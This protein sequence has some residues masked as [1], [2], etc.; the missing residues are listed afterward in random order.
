MGLILLTCHFSRTARPI[1]RATCA[2]RKRRRNDVVKNALRF[3]IRCLV[4]EIYAIK[5]GQ[6]CQNMVKKSNFSEN[7]PTPVPLTPDGETTSTPHYFCLKLHHFAFRM[8][9]IDTHS[10]ISIPSK[11]RFCKTLSDFCAKFATFQNHSTVKGLI[12]LRGAYSNHGHTVKRKISA[13]KSLAKS[14]HPTRIHRT[15]D[16]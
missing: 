11:T 16:L 1:W 6:F 4:L 3:S 15:T 10:F 7:T 5:V 9:P 12:Q 2:T 13:G 8:T 14:Y